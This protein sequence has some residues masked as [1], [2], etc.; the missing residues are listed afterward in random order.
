[1]TATIF[2]D[3]GLVGL[4][5]FFLWRNGEPV[6]RIGWTWRHAVRELILGVACFIPVFLGTALLERALLRAG[7]SA[8]AT[9]LPSLLKAQGPAEGLLAVLLVAVVALAEKSGCCSAS[10]PSYRNT[11]A[12]LLLSSAIFAVGHGYDGSAG[13]ATVGIMEPSSPSSTCGGGA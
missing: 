3:F 13:L 5:L 11:T 12:S 8:P 9:A 10:R 4:I 7:P 2:R 6:S 1:L